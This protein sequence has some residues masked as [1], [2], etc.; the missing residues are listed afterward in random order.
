MLFCAT[1][2][3]LTVFHNQ[4][5]IKSHIMFRDKIINKKLD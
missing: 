4:M 3:M 2:I 1:F 5:V